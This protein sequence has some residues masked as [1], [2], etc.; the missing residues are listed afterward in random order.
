MSRRGP[1][2]TVNRCKATRSPARCVVAPPALRTALHVGSALLLPTP[3]EA[4]LLPRA[5]CVAPCDGFVATDARDT[6]AAPDAA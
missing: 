6:D 3:L 1:E 5:S 4:W 2:P